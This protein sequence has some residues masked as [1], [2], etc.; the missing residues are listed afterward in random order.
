MSNFLEECSPVWI[1]KR[2]RGQ[3][4]VKAVLDETKGTL[5]DDVELSGA[6]KVVSILL[7]K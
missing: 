5:E 3:V 4:R 7:H 6:V 1:D 2:V